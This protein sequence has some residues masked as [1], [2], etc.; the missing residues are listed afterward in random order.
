MN[1]QLFIKIQ[2]DQVEILI[3]VDQYLKIIL[4]TLAQIDLLLLLCKHVYLCFYPVR[5][6][7]SKIGLFPDLSFMHALLFGSLVGAT[8][9][10]S[11]LAVFKK[12]G[13]G[14]AVY[15]IVFGDSALNDAV[16]VVMY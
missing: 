1:T 2:F 12:L 14:G 13:I 9:P 8:D 3:N 6:L 10:V 5:Y 15:T 16:A 4:H 11:V 7:G